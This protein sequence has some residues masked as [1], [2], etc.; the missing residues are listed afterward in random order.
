MTK[1][2]DGAV[3][4]KAIGLAVANLGGDM[5]RPIISQNQIS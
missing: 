3:N 1:V 2:K 4:F 5:V